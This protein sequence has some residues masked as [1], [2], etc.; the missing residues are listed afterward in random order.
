[1]QYTILKDISVLWAMFHVL[2]IFV[3]FYRSKY[4]KKKTIQ[5]TVLF[6]GPLII[7]NMIGVVLYGVDAVGKVVI[8]TCTLPSLVFFYILSADKN[9][10]FLFTFCV[11]DTVA[12]WILCI[13]RMLD[14]FLCG[15]SYVLLFI[16]RL[17]L[18]PVVEYIAFRYL[19]KPYRELLES[20]T[21][22]WGFFT[23]MAAI[24][25]VLLIVQSEFPIVIVE[26][27]DELPAFILTLM[28]M[29]LVYGTMFISLYRQLQVYRK[30]E[31]D[32]VLQEQ[33]LHLERQLE[34]QQK[35]R[36]MKHDMKAHTVTLSG[37]LQSGNIEEAKT[38]LETME[39][40][41]DT[42]QQYFCVNPYL[43]SVISHYHGK[44]AEIGITL[45]TDIRIGNEGLPH[46]EVCQI[47]TNGLENA[48]DEI[49]HLD[50]EEK[51]V[52]LQVRYKQ[53]YLI[54]RIK[55]TCQEE[56]S[57]EKGQLPNTTKSGA[58]HGFGLKSI[59][60]AAERLN[61]EAFCYTEAGNF[62]LDVMLMVGV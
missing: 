21:G 6:M 27:T 48:L 30:T 14:Y 22:S 58:E 19:R 12:M 62:V 59:Q 43:N 53:D 39:T 46:M 45:K 26:R 61:G 55:N 24:Y 47:L 13:T 56:L 34:D 31:S 44:F 35:I 10:K 41:L 11:A 37:L 15:D 25:Y 9:T 2:I 50:N 42:I 36:K 33:T 5:L 7:L 8:L 3:A 40:S 54:I 51:A 18:Y 49:K 52:S 1:M 38:Y 32:R 17:I 16:T 60:E 23:M 4:E 29:P 28:L 57:I 20:V